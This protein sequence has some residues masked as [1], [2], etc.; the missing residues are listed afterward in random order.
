MQWFAAELDEAVL[1]SIDAAM[2]ADLVGCSGW[3]QNLIH[4]MAVGLDAAIGDRIGREDQISGISCSY[5]RLFLVDA[6]APN[7]FRKKRRR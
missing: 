3:Q 2:A 6:T 5:F 7:R 4:K 1:S